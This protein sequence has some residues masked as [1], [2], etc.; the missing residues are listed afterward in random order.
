MN[1]YIDSRVIDKLAYAYL[2]QNISIPHDLDEDACRSRPFSNDKPPYCDIQDGS[3]YS[4][5]DTSEMI[6]KQL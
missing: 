5:I 6:K 4:M 2:K 3:H 1:I